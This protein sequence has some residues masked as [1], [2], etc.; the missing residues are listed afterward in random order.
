M[1]DARLNDLGLKY[2]T[3]KASIGHDYLDHYERILQSAREDSF[4]FIEI[5]GFMGASL[6]MWSDF[7][8]HATIICIDISPSVKVFERERIA[9]EIGDAS[10]PAFLNGI[11]SK[12]GTAR[13]IVDDGSHRWDHQ[14]TTL[15]TLFDMV[16]P[17]GWYIIEDIHTSYEPGFAGHADQPFAE[18][19][20]RLVSYLHLRG[21]HRKRFEAYYGQNLVRIARE[22]DW[23]TFIPRACIIKKRT[24]AKPDNHFTIL[25]EGTYEDVSATLIHVS[26]PEASHRLHTGKMCGSVVKSDEEKLCSPREDRIYSVDEAVCFPR[27]IISKDGR[28]CRI[29]S[30]ATISP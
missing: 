3:D 8:A 27:Q 9:V 25:I 7:F 6:S 13:I 4:N 20:N 1:T 28:I 18:L 15:Y 19:L 29:Y 26:Q 12:Y 22:I 5:G 2:G 24:T 23:I 21:D 16:E 14:K 30:D 10:S 11:K 17:G